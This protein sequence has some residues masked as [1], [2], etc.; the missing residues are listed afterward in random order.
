M[1]RRSWSEEIPVIPTRCRATIRATLVALMLAVGACSTTGDEGGPPDEA[2]PTT[3]T[4]EPT[5]TI[6]ADQERGEGDDEGDGWP[7]TPS[8]LPEVLA[9][10]E[11]TSSPGA[12]LEAPPVQNG[13]IVTNSAGSWMAYD[14]Q[15]GQVWQRTVP[16]EP[17]GEHDE[18]HRLAAPQ[19][20]PWPGL[21]HYWADGGLHLLDTATGRELA[22]PASGH[23]APPEH[24]VGS[25]GHVALALPAYEVR[26]PGPGN[27]L[28]DLR[29]LTLV[30]VGGEVATYG[31]LSISPSGDAY[32]VDADSGERGPVTLVVAPTAAPD[33]RSW[34]YR[35]PA[36]LAFASSGSFL[37]D[38]S[39]EMV[40][41]ASSSPRTY[42]YVG[43]VG[44]PLRLEST[45]ETVARRYPGVPVV[46][47]GDGPAVQ[48]AD[49]SRYRFGPGAPYALACGQQGW[50]AAVGDEVI[51]A[52]GPDF[53]SA[54]EHDWS[55]GR[56]TEVR[57]S[58]WAD[59]LISASDGVQGL[60]DCRRV[61]GV[62][63]RFRRAPLRHRSGSG[64]DPCLRPARPA[65]LGFPR[66]SHLE[67]WPRLDLL[68]RRITR[69]DAHRPGGRNWWR[70]P[71]VG[72]RCRGRGGVGLDRAPGTPLGELAA[73]LIA[74]VRS[75]TSPPIDPAR[76]KS[77]FR[78]PRS[79]P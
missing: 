8:E 52:F 58:R 56:V 23:L 43:P 21:V 53:Q 14:E 13:V 27:H 4:V 35:A 34:E 32:V 71:I 25:A 11:L 51:V 59:V 16:V 61:R 42:H 67:R 9:P 22:V 75:E 65:G 2:E 72:A 1:D 50:R 55:G 45:A 33:E 12:E 68:R 78:G 60:L 54:T 48:L 73:G 66:R 36:G 77:S 79:A 31:A 49:G 63:L 47:D 5:T 38:G 69:R 37:E 24:A 30:S 57:S 19:P 17:T 3:T 18:P 44:E 29:K 28:I 6:T 62:H 10:V 41:R 46:W 76:G 64:A 40:L 7:E 20:L 39:L 26:D 70:D 15:L 74:P